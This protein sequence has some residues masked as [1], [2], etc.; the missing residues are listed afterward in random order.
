[1]T[2]ASI[3]SLSFARRKRAMQGSLVRVASNAA[4]RTL[5]TDAISTIAITFCSAKTRFCSVKKRLCPGNEGF[6]RAKSIQK[7]FYSGKTDFARAKSAKK[8][9]VHRKSIKRLKIRPMSLHDSPMTGTALQ[10]LKQRL[11][12][13]QPPELGPG[14]RPNSQEQTRLEKTLEDVFRGTKLPADKQELVRA[15]AL[16]WHDHLEAAHEIA[17]DI[18]NADGAFIHGIVHR[19]EPDYGNAK[20]WFRRVGEHPAFG[21]LAVRVNALLESRTE[22]SLREVLI[23]GGAWDPFAFI[24]SCEKESRQSDADQ[25]KRNLRAIQAIE[26]EVLL[27]RFCRE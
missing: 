13:G 25:R 26:F 14:P 3:R 6:A 11:C 5:R 24:D 20:Y 21:E 15:L 10:E 7:K 17:Q 4:R 8:S 22:P 2:W 27:E 9:N 16:L 19:R 1:M 12:T 18:A 23:P